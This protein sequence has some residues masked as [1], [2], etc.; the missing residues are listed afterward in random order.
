MPDEQLT[1]KE[2]LDYWRTSG[3]SPFAAQSESF[4]HGPTQRELVRETVEAAKAS[5]TEIA[6][7]NNAWV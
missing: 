4:F 3:R 6:P 5:G 1:F 2:K 7:V